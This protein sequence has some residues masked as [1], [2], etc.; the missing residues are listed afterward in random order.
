MF[1]LDCNGLVYKPLE[2]YQDEGE[3]SY[4]VQEDIGKR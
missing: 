4:C 2:L 3:H 1:L